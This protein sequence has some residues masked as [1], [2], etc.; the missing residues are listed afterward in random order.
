M[1]QLLLIY[2]THNA[3]N[4]I[5]WQSWHSPQEALERNFNYYPYSNRWERLIVLSLYKRGI[6][7][8]TRTGY[9]VYAGIR[10]KTPHCRSLRGAQ[11]LS[12]FSPGQSMINLSIP[13]FSVRNNRKITKIPIGI[14]WHSSDNKFYT[15]LIYNI[16]TGKTGWSSVPWAA[17]ITV[18]T[19]TGLIFNFQISLNFCSEVKCLNRA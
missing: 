4:A 10:K 7:Q 14:Y 16:T 2:Y 18:P 9:F 11:E 1:L 5:I 17:R 3:N 15:I 12:I 19:G 8:F 6:L 13:V